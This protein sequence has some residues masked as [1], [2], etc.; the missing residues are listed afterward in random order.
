[1][2]SHDSA[3]TGNKYHILFTVYTFSKGEKPHSNKVIP[4]VLGPKINKLSTCFQKSMNCSLLLNSTFLYPN[5][6]PEK[7]FKFIVSLQ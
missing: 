5:V 2:K 7:V 1:M 4:C 6:K 3:I